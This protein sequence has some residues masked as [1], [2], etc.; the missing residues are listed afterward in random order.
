MFFITTII[1][2]IIGLLAATITDLKER[3]VPNKLN[4]GLTVIGLI[5]FGIQSIV[6]VNVWPIMYSFFGMCFGFF[7]GWILWKF[8]VF[9][10]GDVKLFMALG[11]LNPFT[12]ALLKIDMFTNISLPIFPITLF[13]YALLAFL[14]YGLFV[15]FCKLLKNKKERKKI[16]KELKKKSLLAIHSS[17]FISGILIITSFFTTNYFFLLVTIFLTTIFWSKLNEKKKYLTIITIILGIIINFIQFIES[18]IIITIILV[19]VYGII[20]LLFLMKP[21]LSKKVKIEKLEEGM[22]PSKTLV[23][24]GKKVIQK[25]PLKLKEILFLLK[26]NKKIEHEKEIVSAI[27][28]RGVTLEEIKELKK[29]AKKGFIPKTILVKDTIPFVPTILLGYLISL[30]LG[31]FIIQIILLV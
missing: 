13:L 15:V 27:K 31:D 8:G 9:A 11:A 4:F 7:F 29:L 12:P 22:I 20:R 25:E 3:I 23:L 30:L 19:G 18:F 2:S 24:R 6:D 14:P 28:A 21:L 26:N 16:T 17:F 5:I 10:G 1:I